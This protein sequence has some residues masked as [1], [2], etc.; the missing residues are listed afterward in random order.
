VATAR[1]RAEGRGRGES[2]EGGGHRRGG[3]F[4]ASLGELGG[5]EPR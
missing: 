4:A 2:G 1:G 5:S 3:H